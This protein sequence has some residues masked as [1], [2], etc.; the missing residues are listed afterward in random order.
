[1]R[2]LT[3]FQ[4][5]LLRGAAFCGPSSGQEIKAW[6]QTQYGREITHGQLYPNLD[7]IIQEDLMSKGQ[8][9]RRTNEYGLTRQGKRY[10]A[11]LAGSWQA[12]VGALDDR[13]AILADGG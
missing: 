6:L 7:T 3:R 4:R 11:E 5:D 2:E 1:M 8:L 13:E 12:A 10:V 9:D